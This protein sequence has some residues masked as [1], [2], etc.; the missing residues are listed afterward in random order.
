MAEA[1][2][3]PSG[4]SGASGG[5]S[6]KDQGNALFKAGNYLKAAAL[7]TQAIKLDP[8]NPTLY[9]NRSAA[10]L[11]LV[12][13]NKAL[14]DAEKTISLNPQWDKGHF[15]KG[16]VLEAMER[17]DDAVAAFQV[18]RQYNPQSTEV[19]KK[20]KRL[21]QL[22]GEKN[23]AL[24]AESIRSNVNMSKYLDPLKTEL[25]EKKGS[26]EECQDI[27]SFIV[28][29]LESAIKNWHET[30]KVDPRVYFLLDKHKTETDKYAPVVNI[31][32]AFESPQ[33]HSSCFSFLRQYAEESYSKAACVVT[34]KSIISYPQV[35]KGQGSRKW[36]HG[37]S[38]GFFV[39]FESPFL[40]KLWFIPSS[41]EKGRT[42]CRDPELL[43][44]GAHE[45]LPRIFKEPSLS[46]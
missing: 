42:L 4:S 41:T 22:A 40:R 21:T 24:E 39:Q 16:C 27:F 11:N 36:K 3:A 17:Y 45:V 29:T 37:N 43:D 25:S 14:A 28:G 18:S 10:F 1:G 15:R 7:Y 26:A 2:G 31:D 34:P 19:S 20:I 5:A 46:T 38:D 12:K 13:L 30:G 33:T 9:S 35:W 8:S 23:R 32:K 44:I 6:L